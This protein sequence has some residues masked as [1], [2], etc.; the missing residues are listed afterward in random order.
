MPKLNHSDLLKFL[1]DTCNLREVTICA[2]GISSIH[3]KYHLREKVKSGQIVVNPQAAFRYVSRLR[4]KLRQ[5]DKS[6]YITPNSPLFTSS[7]QHTTNLNKA[8]VPSSADGNVRMRFYSGFKEA[9]GSSARSIAYFS[10]KER[11]GMERTLHQHTSEANLASVLSSVH[12]VNGRPTARK[13]LIFPGPFGRS[14][15]DRHSLVSEPEKLHLFEALLEQPKPFAEL[16]G[17]FRVSRKNVETLVRKGLLAEVW[18][19]GEICVKFK[20]T[21]KGKKCLEMLHEASNFQAQRSS[22]AR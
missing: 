13:K 14:S 19:P 3:S 11:D 6:M 4:G 22:R 21:Q 10:N 17:I 7:L 20:L 16:Q 2:R 12:A 15:S 18:G 5:R 8:L 1:S 9:E